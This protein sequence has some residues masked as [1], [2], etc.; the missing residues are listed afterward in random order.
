MNQ[1]RVTQTQTIMQTSFPLAS[2]ILQRKCA[3]GQHT[4]GGKECTTCSNKKLNKPLQTK[5]KIGEANDRY[6][7]EADHVAEQVMRMPKPKNGDESEYLQ[8]KLL[9]Q[10][11]VCNTQSGTTEVPSV[12]H[13]VLGSPGLALD[14]TTREFMEPRFD[15]DFSQVRIHTSTK[16]AESAKAVNASAYTVGENVIFS[17]GAYSPNTTIGRELLAHE[18]THYIQQLTTIPKIQRRLTVNRNHPAI[19]PSTDPAASLTPAQRLSMMDGVIQALCNKFEVDSTSGEVLAKS[20]TSMDRTELV[21]G[22]KPTGCCCLSILTDTGTNWT[23]EVSQVIGPHMS[24]HQVVLSPTSTPIEFGSFTSTNSLAFPGAV[25][26][27]GHE[28]CGHAALIEISAHP[29]G[30]DRT[31]TDVHDPTVNIENVISTEQGVPAADLRGLARSGTHRGES[32]DRVTIGDYNFNQKSIPASQSSKVDFTADY[33]IE[34]RSFVDILGHSDNVGSVS[35]KQSVSASRAQNV[36][37]RLTQ[38]GVPTTIS[39]FGLT[40]VNRFTRVEG[41]SDTQPPSLP[42][43]SNQDNWRRTEILIS[44]F[45]AG[46]Q[47]P[48][49]GTPTTVTPHTRAPSLGA[50]RSSTDECVRLLARGAYP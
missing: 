48:P 18:L 32:V 12:V 26:A 29:P 3:C 43:R 7:Q 5:L 46:A 45:P 37:T 19:A 8:A 34:N 27:A 24:G 42:L 50:A 49:T 36:K 28:L 40:S 17:K 15:H 13:E 35:A 30:Q 33:I 23:I 4:Q 47:N 14:Q 39:K 21:N 2:G 41:L 6:E 38:Q 20:R 16:A 10:R 1:Q 11:R 31:T 44:G 9:V 25:P 22:N